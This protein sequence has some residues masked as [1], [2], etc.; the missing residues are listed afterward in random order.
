MHP[1]V[2]SPRLLRTIDSQDP[3]T[4]FFARAKYMSRRTEPGSLDFIRG[5]VHEMPPSGFVEALDRAVVPQHERWYTYSEN[6]PESQ[7]IVSEALK[8]KRGLSVEPEDIFM[9]NGGKAGLSIC[10]QILA[11]EGDEVIIITPPW[12]GYRRMIIDTGAVPVGVPVNPI[13]FD[14][15]LEAL[16][17]AITERTRAI[18]INSPHNPTGKIYSATTLEQLANLLANASDRFGQPIYLIS[19]EVFSR[20]VFDNRSCPSPVQFYPFSFLVYSYS[21]T[22]MT[23][24]QRMGY[25]ALSPNM[26][27]K[28]P[29]RHAIYIAQ[30]VT[31]GWCFPSALMQ[32]A[33]ADIEQIALDLDHLQ[34]KRDWMVKELQ[35]IGYKVQ[36]PEGTFV[37]LVQSPWQDDCAFAELLASHDVFVIPGTPQEIPGYFR[38]SL[39]ASNDMIA[40][41]LPKLKAAMEY[42]TNC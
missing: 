2:I 6:L 24:G 8:A 3:A 38:L 12:L 32:H 36:P 11:G 4:Q 33:L 34:Q 5:D 35:E 42:A 17:S 27:D 23:P 30:R 20:I 18:L 31:F 40:R 9:T 26:P 39:T 10:L 22:L 1:H 41:A 37:L 25:I 13:T 21:K 19:D 29:I 28:E 16:A 15:D 14:L 7:R